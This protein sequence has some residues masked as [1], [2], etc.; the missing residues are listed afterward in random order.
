VFFGSALALAPGHK[1]DEQAAITKPPS[2]GGQPPFVSQ[3]S[4]SAPRPA[5]LTAPSA[6]GSTAPGGAPGA[7]PATPGTRKV[8]QPATHSQ[9]REPVPFLLVRARCEGYPL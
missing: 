6:A 7:L 4:G 8:A 5:H 2:Q 3:W 1:T 9:G